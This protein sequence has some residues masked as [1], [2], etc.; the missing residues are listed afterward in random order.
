MSLI[1]TI[2][3]L[4]FITELIS[5]I[6]KSV[7]LRFVLFFRP[8]ESLSDD[9]T[10]PLPGMDN[11]SATLQPE[12]PETSARAQIRASVEKSRTPADQCSGSVC[13]MGQTSSQ[14]RQRPRG[15]GKAQLRICCRVPFRPISLTLRSRV[16]SELTASKSSFALQFGTALW[17]LTTGLQFAIGWW[18]GRS[19]VFYLPPTWLGPF[20]W[21]LSLPFAPAGELGQS[22]VLWFHQTPG[23]IRLCE[24]WRL[25]DGLSTCHQS[26]RACG[27]RIHESDSPESHMS[28][29]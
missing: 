1:V 22:S 27:K 8:H 5:W 10:R 4:V 3:A 25:A 16:D 29:R 7:L 23:I 12:C 24:L 9:L 19:A 20:T 13:K 18:Y 2:F 26:V 21:W 15:S 17:M 11:I 6:G 28:S 14:R